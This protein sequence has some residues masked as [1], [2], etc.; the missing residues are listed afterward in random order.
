MKIVFFL[1]ATLI[2]LLMA[3]YVTLRGWQALQSAGNLRYWYLG[4]NILLFAVMMFSFMARGVLSPVFM[5]TVTNVG[6]SYIIIMTYLLLSFLIVDIVRLANLAIHFA[7]LGMKS[8][9][10]VAFLISISAIAI[11]M[12]YGNYKF[13]HPEIVNLNLNIEKSPKQKT[14]KIVALS[15]IHLG[16]SINKTNLQRYVKLIN[17]QK[18]DMV[19]MAGDMV[20]NI[21]QPLI[22]Q[23]MAEVL[24]QIVAPLGVYAING[25]HEYYGE[26][27]YI[28]EEYLK[29]GGITF[30]RDSTILVNNSF[31]VV[32]RDDRTNPNRKKIAELT[33]N[34]DHSKPVIML[35]H[36]PYH[37]NE[38]RE[39][40]VDLQISGHTHNGQF[41]PGNLIVKRMYEVGYGYRKIDKTHY[42]VSSGL[43]LWGPKYRIG[44]QSELVVINL[45]F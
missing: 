13:N 5:K 36:Q 24:K 16:Y 40:G 14:I 22:E 32:G 2:T 15:D 11:S 3:S 9:R 35:D 30:L 7:P 23:N 39:N 17:E 31:Y 34:I 19:L 33:S 18:P 42:Y 45:S 25:N 38:A 8:F 44:T 43:G 1:F 20:D 4:A 6:F 21:T 41:F 26:N 28:A 10:Y 29:T 37:L 12:I 27:P